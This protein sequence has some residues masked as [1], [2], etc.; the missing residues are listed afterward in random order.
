MCGFAGILGLSRVG[1]NSVLSEMGDALR[2]RGPDGHGNWIDP[3]GIGF[4]HRRLAIVNLSEAGAQPMKSRDARWV[5]VFNGEIYNHLALRHELETIQARSWRGHSDTETLVEA[6]ASWGVEPTLQRCNGM[7]AIAIWDRVEQI[8]TLVR[9][10]TG[11]KPLYV[12]WVGGDIVFGS[13]LKAFRR[14]PAWRHTVEPQALHWMLQLGYVPAPWSIHPRV[15]KLP[16][17]S[18]LR[19][20]LADTA[21]AFDI[22][23]FSTRLSHYWQLDD[24]ISA[25]RAAPW[26]DSRDAALTAIQTTLDDAVRLRMVADVPVGALLSGGI[27]STLVVA[28]MARQSSQP[29]RTFTVGFETPEL[30]ESSTALATARYWGTEHHHIPLSSDAALAII[31]RMP[32]VYDEPFADVAQ[33]PALLVSEIARRE[34]TVALTGD[35]GDELFQGY[36]RYLDG[37]RIWRQLRRSPAGARRVAANLLDG[38]GRMILP[39]RL[40]QSLKRQATRIGAPDVNDYCRGLSVF[41]GAQRCRLAGPLP[42][43]DLPPALSQASVGERMRFFDQSLALP[44]GIHTKLDRASMAAGL[45]LRVPLLDHR[46]VELAW[47]MPASWMA[48]G[49]TGKCL[50]RALAGRQSPEGVQNLRKQGFDVPVS[51]WLRGPLRAWAEDLL[52]P[53]ALR[54]DPLLNGRHVRCMFGEHLSRRADHGHALW[55]ILMYRTWS[56]RHG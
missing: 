39:G 9:D 43:P 51:S 49:N 1:I 26:A 22:T 54:A 24:V 38:A 19:L 47:R 18:L 23:A 12:G 42:W 37:E 56:L 33:L 55:A 7:F 32:E 53:S 27:D 10:R 14:H 3:A 29:V 31:E 4:V 6:I 5:I 13:E 28:S 25:A 21:K 48:T 45:E 2:H 44:E 8:L 46:L 30:D 11:E 36:Q 20:S 52:A 34:V 17:A 15:F 35:G 41:P 50:L 40:S 16:A